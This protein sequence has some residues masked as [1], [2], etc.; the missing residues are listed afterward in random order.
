M[1]NDLTS[2]SQRLGWFKSK[3]A[4]TTW[5]DIATGVV[6]MG[7]VGMMVGQLIRYNLYIK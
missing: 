7:V 3:F 5:L 1:I 4:R 2:R 6:I